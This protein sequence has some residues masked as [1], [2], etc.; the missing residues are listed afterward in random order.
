MPFPGAES[1]FDCQVKPS[2]GCRGG[3][4]REIERIIARPGAS[5]IVRVAAVDVLNA[6]SAVGIPSFQ[7][8]AFVVIP[9][10]RD[11]ASIGETER[12]G[13]TGKDHR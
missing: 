11:P 13:V 6:F 9:G 2:I 8:E 4:D 10:N 3:P 1:S 5:V 12:P 7:Q